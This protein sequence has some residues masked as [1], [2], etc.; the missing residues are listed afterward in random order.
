MLSTFVSRSVILRFLWFLWSNTQEKAEN[1]NFIAYTVVTAKTTT[2]P[3]YIV[4]CIMG[5]LK[6]N[7]FLVGENALRSE[8]SVVVLPTNNGI[9]AMIDASH[10]IL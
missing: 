5:E 3:W 6:R 10:D 9:I 4:N 8:K 1:N 7:L 2:A